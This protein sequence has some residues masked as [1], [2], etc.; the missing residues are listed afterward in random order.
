[1]VCGDQQGDGPLTLNT[2]SG[3]GIGLPLPN[4][5][6]C[7][8][9]YLVNENWSMGWACA[10]ISHDSLAS[11]QRPESESSFVFCQVK[12]GVLKYF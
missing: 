1:V 7:K 4:S 8:T 11:M 5:P 6:F 3:V 12:T 2:S 10:T 9:G